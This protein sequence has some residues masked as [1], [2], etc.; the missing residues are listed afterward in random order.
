[1][2]E[3]ED[4]SLGSALDYARAIERI[5]GILDG[6]EWDAGTIEEV[7]QVITDVGLEIR[8]PEEAPSEWTLKATIDIK[9][10]G[11]EVESVTVQPHQGANVFVLWKDG[12]ADFTQDEVNEALSRYLD[13]TKVYLNDRVVHRIGWEG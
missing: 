13:K 12:N 4:T 6:I 10:V 11:T 8:S 9:M 1:M 7:A 2:A 3:A 5:H